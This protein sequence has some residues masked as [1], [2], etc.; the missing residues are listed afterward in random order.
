MV[1]SLSN[2]SSYQINLLMKKCQTVCFFVAHSTHKDILSVLE[3]LFYKKRI[4]IAV[5]LD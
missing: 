5:V 2:F 3:M 1:G 4:E